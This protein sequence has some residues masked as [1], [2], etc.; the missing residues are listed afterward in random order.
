MTDYGWGEWQKYGARGMRGEDALS[1]ELD[2]IVHEHGIKSPVTT[3]RGV[4]ARLNYLKS[5]AGREEMQRMGI[6]ERAVKSWV[7]GKAFPSTANRERLDRAYWSFRR[8]N[9][10]RTGQ[11]EKILN[12]G[13]RGSRIE[14]YPVDQSQVIPG[15]ERP[16]VQQRSI[17]G[18]YLWGPLVEAWAAGDVAG[19]A[20]V[21]FDV[22]QELDSDYGAYEYVSAVGIGA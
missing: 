7:A 15:R 13:G 10:I 14:I 19:M 8:E 11:L 12:D 4:S 1:A 20:D 21:W 17:Q 18:R 3:P 2:R 22:I 6:S 9:L 5:P 16:T